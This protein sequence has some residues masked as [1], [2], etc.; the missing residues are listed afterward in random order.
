ML[1]FLITATNLYPPR[2]KKLKTQEEGKKVEEEGRKGNK[3]GRKKG[4]ENGRK[5]K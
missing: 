3:R 1:V 4:K 2:A 5:V